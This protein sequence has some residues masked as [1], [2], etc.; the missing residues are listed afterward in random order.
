MDYFVNS[1]I[2]NIKLQTLEKIWLNVKSNNEQTL[3]I[4]MM[5]YKYILLYLLSSFYITN[6]N[7]QLLQ[8]YNV[9]TQLRI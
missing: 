7:S 8:L 4:V 3:E 5:L 9:Q 6:F 2:Q 1:S